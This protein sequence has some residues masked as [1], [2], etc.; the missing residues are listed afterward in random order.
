MIL[1]L[2]GSHFI[3][4]SCYTLFINL[5]LFVDIRGG[6]EATEKL[7]RYVCSIQEQYQKNL[8]EQID[9]EIICNVAKHLH[10]WDTKY[11]LLKLDYD[12]VKVIKEENS[13]VRSQR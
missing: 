9:Q 7:Q 4:V 11:D 12:E 13:S 2:P 6:S 1:E 5:I 3:S 8:D 10:N